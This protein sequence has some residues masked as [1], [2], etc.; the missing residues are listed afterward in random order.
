M[1][2]L[3]YEVVYDDIR[4]KMKEGIL[5]SGDQIPPVPQLAEELGVGISS[6]REAIRILA[7]QKII[8]V[9]QGRGTYVS[10]NF[11]DQAPGDRFDFLEN[12]S[13]IQLS[14]ARLVIEPELAALAAEKATREEAEEILAAAKIMSE[15]VKRKQDFFE[16][17]L[18]FHHLISKASRNEILAEMINAFND[19]LLDSRR[20]TVKIKGINEKAA[21]FHVL[22]AEAIV[23]KNPLQ[24]RRL[25]IAHMEDVLYELKKDDR[26]VHLLS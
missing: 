25:M 4:N 15:K 23:Q 7:Q 21:S 3:T 5:K 22:I 9:E 1:K 20:K 13:L 11:E 26:N 2:R 6:V 19:L 24:A 16:E 14:E 12:A 10:Q 17:D 8:K 18:G